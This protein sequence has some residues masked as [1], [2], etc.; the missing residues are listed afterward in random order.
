MPLQTGQTSG[1]P[2]DLRQASICCVTKGLVGATK[3]TLPCSTLE[4]VSFHNSSDL[5]FIVSANCFQLLTC[6]IPKCCLSSATSREAERKAACLWKPSG[7]VVHHNSCNQGFA[8]AGGE[9]HK[10]VVKQSRLYYLCLICSLRDAH[11]VDPRLGSIPANSN[12][13]NGLPVNA[14]SGSLFEGTSSWSKLLEL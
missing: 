8:K 12:F 14:C 4:S 9:A 13:S 7:E 5:S 1:M 2:T 6:R 10:G 3:T 11:R